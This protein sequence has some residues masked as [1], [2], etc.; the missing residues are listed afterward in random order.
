MSRDGKL[1][2]V[3][4][5]FFIPDTLRTVSEIM[6]SSKLIECVD[7]L[8]ESEVSF[9][10]DDLF[11]R[12]YWIYGFDQYGIV[13]GPVAV[14]VVPVGIST[15]NRAEVGMYPNPVTS[16]LTIH[17]NIH[18]LYDLTISSLNGQLI[19][20]SIFEGSSHQLDLSSFQK[21]V[22][23]VTIRSRDFVTTKK[24]IKY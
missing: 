11:T 14:E 15:I 12:A 18:S 7:A 22:Y 10:T 1:C 20:D 8:A 3:A 16:I 9:S 6:S 2:L 23:F 21:G 4:P 5:N 19:H 24:I 17:M 13:T